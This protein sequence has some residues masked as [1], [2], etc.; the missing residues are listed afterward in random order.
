MIP[1]LDFGSRNRSCSDHE[2]ERDDDRGHVILLRRRFRLAPD[3]DI[4]PP[5]MVSNDQNPEFPEQKQQ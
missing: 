4:P 1:N 3:Q 5:G 2:L